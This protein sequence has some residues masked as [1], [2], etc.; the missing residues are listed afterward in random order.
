MQYGD[1]YYVAF[2]KGVLRRFDRL[3]SAPHTLRNG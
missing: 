3:F 1:L 2:F